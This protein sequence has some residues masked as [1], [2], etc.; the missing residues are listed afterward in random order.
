M[1]Q[2]FT[3]EVEYNGHRYLAEPRIIT[4]SKGYPIAPCKFCD[5]IAGVVKFAG[6][7]LRRSKKYRELRN[8]ILNRSIQNIKFKQ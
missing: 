4:D 5:E 8:Q 3:T 6:H 2:V 1:I 7:T